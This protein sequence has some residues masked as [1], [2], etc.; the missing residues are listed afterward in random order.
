[1]WQYQ[2]DALLKPSKIL[3]SN[4]ILWLKNAIVPLGKHDSPT[5]QPVSEKPEVRMQQKFKQVLERRFGDEKRF[6]KVWLDNIRH[7]GT[8]LPTSSWTGKSMASHI[9]LASP[10]PVLELGPGTGPVTR[11]I[12]NRGIS[13]SRLIAVEYSDAFVSLL[14]DRHPQIRILQGDAFNLV[15]ALADGGKTRFDTIIS[16]IPLLNFPP[17]KRV[18]YVQSMLDRMAPG[19]PL[20]QITYGPLCPAPNIPGVRAHRADVVFRNLPPSHIWTFRRI[21]A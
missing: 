19:R 8:P 4:D 7:V 14:Q 1:V 16:G 11:E 10:L 20:V 6:F 5:W 12:L 18:D 9:D 21:T 2:L 17:E 13:P 15:G 3:S